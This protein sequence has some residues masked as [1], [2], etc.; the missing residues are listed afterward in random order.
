MQVLTFF[1]KSIVIKIKSKEMKIKNDFEAEIKPYEWLFIV[2]AVVI[3]ILIINGDVT[4]AI[5]ALNRWLPKPK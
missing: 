1:L 2:A 3:V 5:E 4:T